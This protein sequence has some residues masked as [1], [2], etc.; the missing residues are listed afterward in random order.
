VLCEYYEFE[1]TG[2]F[3]RRTRPGEASGN[4]GATIE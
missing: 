1:E 4:G 2:K 3:E